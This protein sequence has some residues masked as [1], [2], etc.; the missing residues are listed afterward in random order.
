M[1]KVENMDFYAILDI[2][3]DA[4]EKEVKRAFHLFSRSRGID[5]VSDNKVI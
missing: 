4:N 3:I 1:T 2:S 5:H